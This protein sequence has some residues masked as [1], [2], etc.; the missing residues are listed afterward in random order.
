LRAEDSRNDN[1]QG[2]EIPCGWVAPFVH[3]LNASMNMLAPSGCL[4]LLA[5]LERSLYRR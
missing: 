4:P 3:R 1:R 5:C 2:N